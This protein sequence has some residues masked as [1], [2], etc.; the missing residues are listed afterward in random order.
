MGWFNLLPGSMC[1]QGAS[2][3]LYSFTRNSNLNWLKL[4]A[5]LLVYFI[6]LLIQPPYEFLGP[7]LGWKKD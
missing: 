7:N 4:Y 3:V 2:I 5:T 1:L 6:Q